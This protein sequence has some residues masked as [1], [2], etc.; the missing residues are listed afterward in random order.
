MSNTEYHI[1]VLLNKAIEYLLNDKIKV[2]VIADGTL[3]GGGY[4]GKICESLGTDDALICIDKDIN[5]IDHAK[6]ILRSCSC[7]IF[8]ANN[9]FAEIKEIIAELGMQKISGLVLDLGLSTYQLDSEDGF[10]YMKETK[11]DMRADKRGD[12]KASDVLNSFSK[13]DLTSVFEEYGEIGNATRLSEM[14]V[15]QRKKRKFETTFDLVNAI[16]VEYQINPKDRISF[17]SK[18]FQSIRI[19]VNGEMEDLKKVLSDAA[20]VL[21]P[22][23]RLVIVSYHSLED[24]I[25]KNYFKDSSAKY[26]QGDHPFYSETNDQVFKVLTKKAIIPE[27]EEIRMNSRSRSAKLRA[28]E[29]I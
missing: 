10:S 6:E 5:A 12:V 18:I 26:K 3:G 19:E 24:R 9:N 8:L 21:E 22:G 15:S 11:L 4:S 13:E 2:K 23:G 17:L 20:E 16:D 25:V 7:R 1:P 27:A 29:R 28:A 14:I